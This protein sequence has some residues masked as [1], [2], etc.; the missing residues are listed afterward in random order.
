MS[1]TKIAAAAAFVLIAPI[2]TANAA[3]LG[4]LGTAPAVDSGIVQVHGRHN[5]CELGVAG[6]HRSP[7]RGVRIACRPHRPRGA[8]WIWRSEGPRHGWY[9]RKERRWHH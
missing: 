6:W 4:N 2:A 3:P 8:F 7:R 5:T 9:H 1:F